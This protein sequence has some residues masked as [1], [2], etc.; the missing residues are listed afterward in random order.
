M[1]LSH[2]YVFKQMLFTDM[3]LVRRGFKDKVI[4]LTIWFATQLIV[5][6]YLMPYLG[7]PIK[8]IG[9]FLASLAASGGLFEVFPSAVTLVADME[10]DK[11]IE[12]NFTLPVPSW[13]VLLKMI[14]YY[15]VNAAI[16]M[17]FVLPFG[18]LISWGKVDITTISFVKYGLLFI[19]TSMFYGSFTLLVASR[20][21]SMLS[22]GSGW[23]RFV[24]PI[25]FLGC[26]QF[27]WQALYSWSPFFAYVNLLNPM[28]YVMEGTRAAI[29]GQQNFLNYWLC[30]IMTLFFSVFYA[31]WSIKKLKKRL[32]FV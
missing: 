21:K 7:F 31:W 25:W 30:L 28:V 32:D 15:S 20:I 12:Y 18:L 5:F 24:Y 16:Q 6:A 11:I 9:F 19:A 2:L 23:M 1:E 8:Y 22:I 10:G 17:C 4:N 3:V 14:V 26:F 29:L 27:S 13:M